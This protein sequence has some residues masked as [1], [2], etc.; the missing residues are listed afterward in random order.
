MILVTFFCGGL[1]IQVVVMCEYRREEWER[2]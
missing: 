1:E 2:V